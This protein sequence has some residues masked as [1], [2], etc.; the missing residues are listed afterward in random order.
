MTVY[1]PV[2]ALERGLAVL[3]ATN[4]LAEP[5]VEAIA[6]LTKLPWST[7]FRL[8]ETLEAAGYV[9]RS[10]NGHL[11]RPSLLARSLG[12]GYVREAWV[13]Q[14]ATPRIAE[15]SRRLVWPIDL[16]VF[17]NDS[18]LI[19]ESTQ[20]TSPFSIDRNMVGRRTPVLMTSS[21]RAYISF[22]PSR[23]R[24]AIIERLTEKTNEEG[25]LARNKCKLDA[26]IK[27]TRQAGFA[28]RE[29]GLFP[30]TKSISVPIL[31]HGRVNGCIS[32]I[33]IA[34]AL[35]LKAGVLQFAEPLKK[36]AALIAAEI[37]A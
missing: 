21:G 6:R 9:I 18:M 25:Q 23:E 16:I 10:S 22:V 20:R 29:G 13:S 2:R 34:S 24:R 5:T 30:H 7:A 12:E 19:V 15:L 35:T 8:L 32:I 28:T 11:Y 27:R 31:A 17:D 14:F 1:R 26:L 37:P 4:T 3:K 33:W 36:T